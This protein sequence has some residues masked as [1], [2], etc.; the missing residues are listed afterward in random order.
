MIDDYKCTD[1]TISIAITLEAIDTEAMLRFV[2][3]DKSGAT[4]LFMGTTRRLTGE[5]ET[6]R[7]DYECYETMAIKKMREILDEARSK[8][9][10]EKASMAHRT[11]TVDVGQTSVAI[12]VS[13]AHRKVAF[14][15]AEWLIDTLKQV[16]PIWKQ[17]CW[18]DGSREWVHPGFHKT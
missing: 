16:V 4:V 5:R 18:A 14:E 2:N 9:A 8:W 1:E 7:L 3:S 11:G 10:F 15:A 17:E 13:A 6:T 12:A